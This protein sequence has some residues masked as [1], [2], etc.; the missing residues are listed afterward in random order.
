[1]NDQENDAV[2]V[3]GMLKRRRWKGLPMAT[4][5]L[6]IPPG[7]LD[8]FVVRTEDQACSECSQG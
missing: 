6:F 5:L 7:S 3:P 1:M 8:L 4:A 2:N